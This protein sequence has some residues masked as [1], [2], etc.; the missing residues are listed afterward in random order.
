MNSAPLARTRL[1]ALTATTVAAALPLGLHV[2]AGEAEAAV[3]AQVVTASS[4]AKLSTSLAQAQPGDHLRLTDGV[5]SS[6]TIK[7][8]RSGTAEQPITISAENRGRTTLS[9]T[10]RIDLSGVSHVIVTGFVF[11]TNK[12]LS[13]PAG[14][15]ANRITRNVF[16]GNLGNSDLSVA[17]NDTEVD[18]N[19]FQNRTAAGVYLQVVGPGAHD[20]AKR[21]HVHHNYF[22]NHQF[23]G[24]N[25]GESIRFG[26]SS[27]QHGV[28][29]GLIEKNLFE[30]ANGD[31]E[32]ISIKSSNNVVRYNTILNS[33]GTISLRHGSNTVVEGNLLLG[34]RTGIRFFGNNQTIINN[35]VQDTARLPMEVGGGEIRDDTDNTTAHEAADN[36]LVAF[37]TITG[38]AGNVVTYRGGKAFPPS[39]IAFANNIV[40]GHGS[41][42]V[43]GRG[44]Q[45]TFQGNILTGAP[46]GTMPTG[47]FR[48]VNPKLIRDG[49][50]LLR[51]SSGSPTIGAAKGSFPQVTYDVDRQTRPTA[52]DVGA[53]Q[54]NTATPIHP[55]TT[56]EVGPNAP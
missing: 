53:D 29:N 50:N 20:M 7:V 45:L 51:P 18:H 34:G 17:A 8:T 30:K 19:T 44:G 56:A 32:G 11:T 21:V 13:V 6:G 3:P 9:G 40:I 38:T 35:V 1:A 26:L 2:L 49:H 31:S 4:I 5:Y 46:A 43:T 16:Q 42:A 48:S 14:A 36:C 54:F 41:A 10:A 37:N 52:K 39:H 25:G 27:R 22:F 15:A 28:A 24:T 47:G 12:G 33:N 23:K 55:L